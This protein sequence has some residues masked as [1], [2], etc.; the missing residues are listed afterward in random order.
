MKCHSVPPTKI[1]NI[2]NRVLNKL[3]RK[4]FGNHI[5]IRVNSIHFLSNCYMDNGLFV[6]EINLKTSKRISLDELKNIDF[7]LLN[8]LDTILKMTLTDIYVK[9][10]NIR[11]LVN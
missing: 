7:F 11:L 6:P 10:I 2:A 9:I 1:L 4:R 8:Q 5:T 3:V